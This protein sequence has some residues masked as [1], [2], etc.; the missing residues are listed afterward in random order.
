MA[1]HVA[2]PDAAM[3]VKT[4]LVEDAAAGST[5]AAEEVGATAEGRS[6]ESPGSSEG[7]LNLPSDTAET[8][9]VQVHLA[10]SSSPLACVPSCTRA[11]PYC[12]T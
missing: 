2:D 3:P 6:Q 11:G 5:G 4:V 7:G 10:T 12:R 1:L 8:H 9:L